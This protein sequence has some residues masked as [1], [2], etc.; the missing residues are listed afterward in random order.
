MPRRATIDTKPTATSETPGYLSRCLVLQQEDTT[1]H[2]APL[3]QGLL[4]LVHWQ[5]MDHINYCL[6]LAP[7]DCHLHGP[8]KQCLDVFESTK[9]RKWKSLYVDGCKTKSPI[10]TVVKFEIISRREKIHQV[11]SGLC[12]KI[13]V[14]R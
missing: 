13:L 11:P 3:M 12:W 9:I 5:I 6:D 7:S 2:S 4:H 10:S 14:F 8:L 1:Q